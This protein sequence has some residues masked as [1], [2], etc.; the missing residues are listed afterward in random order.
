MRRYGLRGRT[1]CVPSCQCSDD[2]NAIYLPKTT[3]GKYLPPKLSLAVV[4]LE[5]PDARASQARKLI[6]E[7]CREHIAKRA[8]DSTP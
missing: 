3:H 7:I 1:G 5:S 8:G 2:E 6:G 4:F